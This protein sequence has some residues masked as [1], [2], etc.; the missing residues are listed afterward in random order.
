LDLTGASTTSGAV[1]NNVFEN[2]AVVSNTMPSPNY[3]AYSVSA[4]KD[5]GAKSFVYTPGTQ[6]VNEPNPNSPT[7]ANFQ[8]TAAG[9][10]T[11]GKGVTLPAPYNVNP[12]GATRG[13]SGVW[14]IGAY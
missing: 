10:T 6:F 5:P 7:A 9:E 8:L 14:Y 13:A 3:N 2:V 4:Y 12:L 11:F 1:Q